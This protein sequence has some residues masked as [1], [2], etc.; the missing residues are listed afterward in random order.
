MICLPPEIMNRTVD[1][2]H[3][4]GGGAVEVGNIRSDRV[5]AAELDAGR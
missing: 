1:F 3:Q 4:L 5:L 2:N